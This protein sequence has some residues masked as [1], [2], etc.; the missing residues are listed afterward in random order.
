[1][2]NRATYLCNAI[3]E[4]FMADHLKT[5]LPRINTKISNRISRGTK[6]E[7]CLSPVP[8]VGAWL[9]RTSPSPYVLLCR[10]WLFTSRGVGKIS[11]Q[12]WGALG[13]TRPLAPGS[14]WPLTNSPLPMWV[15]MPNLIAVCQTVRAYV[16]D[17]LSSLRP[18]FQGHTRSPELTRIDRVSMTFSDPLPDMG[19]H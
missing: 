8:W 4:I 19:A 7:E 18:A 5:P 11:P 16:R 6:N 3:Y 2:T 13:P 10:I 12:N 17:V 1:M 9:T 15:T 14:A